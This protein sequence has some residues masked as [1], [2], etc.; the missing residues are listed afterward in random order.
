MKRCQALVDRNSGICCRKRSESTN[1]D[2][3]RTFK[4]RIVF[5][6]HA[7][8]DQ[9]AERLRCS[10]IAAAIEEPLWLDMYTWLEGHSAEQADAI[11]AYIH[12]D[13]AETEE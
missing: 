10:E 6:R 9:N 1:S 13:Q 3:R 11:L 12:S 8:W 7:I 5:G 4:G 2:P